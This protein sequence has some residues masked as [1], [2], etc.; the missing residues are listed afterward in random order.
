M[1]GKKLYKSAVFK[2]D[3]MCA[4]ANYVFTNLLQF[5]SIYAFSLFLTTSPRTYFVHAFLYFYKIFIHPIL[6]YLQNSASGVTIRLSY[7]ILTCQ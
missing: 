3:A 1:Y 4:H 5:Q 7:E 6:F 2:R